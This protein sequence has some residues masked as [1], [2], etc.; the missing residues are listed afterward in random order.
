MFNIYH[1]NVLLKLGNPKQN[2]EH[3][4]LQNTAG[5]STS[6]PAIEN[7]AV[8]T[9]FESTTVQFAGPASAQ[10][11]GPS[12]AQFAGPASAQFAEQAIGQFVEPAVGESIQ[13]EVEAAVQI[14]NDVI[15]IVP[16]SE[17]P[18]ITNSLKYKVKN[19][20]WVSI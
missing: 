10:F 19:W 17:V 3:S 6:Q 18:S 5:P 9:F 14:E 1:C 7:S 4:I 13:T 11:A 12:S 8:Q 16:H 20:S 2:V 15:E